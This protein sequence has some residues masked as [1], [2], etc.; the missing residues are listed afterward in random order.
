MESAVEPTSYSQNTKS[1]AP[2]KL[3]VRGAWVTV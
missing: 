3:D 2:A 1:E